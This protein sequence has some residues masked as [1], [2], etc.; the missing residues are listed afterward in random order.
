MTDRRDDPGAGRYQIR[1]QGRLE[2]N[3]AAWFDGMTVSVGGDGTT[4]VTGVVP[5]QAALHGVIQRVRDLGIPLVS[6]TRI[7][8]DPPSSP[9]SPPA[10][11]SR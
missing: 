8:P 3:W 6:V 7:E 9:D 4:V 10:D 5:D 1:L 11:H 2:P